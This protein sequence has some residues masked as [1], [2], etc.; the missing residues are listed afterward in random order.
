MISRPTWLVKA[1]CTSLQ[2]VPRQQGRPQPNYKESRCG[3]VP[4]LYYHQG[5]EDSAV[6]PRSSPLEGIELGAQACWALH[7][8]RAGSVVYA[9]LPALEAFDYST[10][11]NACLVAVL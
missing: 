8:T 5:V 7:S 6:G 10:E 1:Y 2:G 9:C 3:N 4:V 11:N